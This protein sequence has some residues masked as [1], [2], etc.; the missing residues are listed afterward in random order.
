M[1]QNS[2]T[3]TCPKCNHSTVKNGFRKTGEQR[4]LCKFCGWSNKSDRPRGRIKKNKIFCIE[5]NAT[6]TYAH[7]RCEACYRR[8]RRLLKS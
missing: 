2:T 6:P 3:P 1:S 7:D 5:C 4:Y 8:Y